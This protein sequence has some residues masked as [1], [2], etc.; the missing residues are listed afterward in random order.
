MPKE[1]LKYIEKYDKIVIHRHKRPDMDAIGSQMGLY[2]L[3]K[4][5]Y[6]NKKVYV[7]GDSNDFMYKAV[8][9]EIPDSFYED[10]LAIITDVAV[11][12][13]VS[14]D[15]YKLASEVIVIDHHKNDTDI[16]NVSYFHHLNTYT[17]ACQIII[18]LAKELNLKVNSDAATYLYAGMV[19]DTGRFN[20]INSDNASGVFSSAAFI[21]KFN[22]EI[23]EIYNFLY[24]EDLDKRLTKDMFRSFEVTPNR[25]AY[26]KNMQAIIDKSGLDIFSVSRGMVNLMAGIKEIPIWASFTEDSEN[27]VILA[28]LRSRDITIVD[29]AKKYGGGGH[30]NACGASLKDFEEVDLM[31]KDLDERA[32]EYGSIK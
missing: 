30:N 24:T 2:Y 1:A 11:S 16:E 31:L 32:K 7:V 23:N 4:E 13:L 21:T 12:N 18:D 26:R 17:S 20:Y 14:D 19:T 5:N 22:P 9:D 10:A 27:N 3:I 28:E 15:R 25:V 29:I 8:M 6:P